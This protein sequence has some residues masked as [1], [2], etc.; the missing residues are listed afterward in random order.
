MKIFDIALKDLLR[1]YRSAFVIAMTFVAPLLITGIFYLAFGSPSDDGG[2]EISTI[3]LLVVNRDQP[4]QDG[5]FSL[6]A[7][8]TEFLSSESL[9]GLLEVVQEEDEVSARRAVD[10]QEM[11]MAVIIP[12]DFTDSIIDPDQRTS[13]TIYHDPTLTLGPAIVKDIVGQY[14]DAFSGAKIAAGVT[15]AQFSARRASVGEQ[16][17]QQ[18]ATTYSIWARGIGEAQGEG[19][20][21]GFNLLPSETGV[22][23]QDQTAQTLGMI[24][25]SMMIF[26]MFYTGATTAESIIREEEEGT[27]ARLFTTPT[28][29]TVILGGK[30]ITIFVML[31]MQSIVLMLLSG[32]IF[33]IHWGEPLTVALAMIATIISAGGFG[34][35]VMS[36]VKNTRQSG[37]VLG[38]VLV[39]T[40]MLG[41]LFTGGVSN[42]PAALDIAALLMPHGWALRCWKIALAGK[43]AVAALQP[44]AVTSAAGIGFFVIGVILF[45]RRFV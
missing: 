1:S 19:E 21:R 24:M 18:I 2:I 9:D 35:F 43:P 36:F 11:D 26:F 27:L 38:G 8:L 5:E 40:G 31:L 29:T 13:V 25:G 23:V 28:R 15:A 39:V 22:E 42:L 16:L 45:R 10:S 14:V 33:K 34:L 37:Y 6:G 32:Y 30:F 41:G 12:S 7:Y 4:V 20:F 3:H 44:V 17:M